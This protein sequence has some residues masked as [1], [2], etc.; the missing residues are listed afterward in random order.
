MVFFFYFLTASGGWTGS[1][2]EVKN[3]TNCHH[4]SFDLLQ[5]TYGVTRTGLAGSER[6]MAAALS[7][8]WVQERDPPDPR[9]RR[10]ER[11][12]PAGERIKASLSQ[13]GLCDAL[14]KKGEGIRTRQNS[15][16]HRNW[17]AAGALGAGVWEFQVKGIADERLRRD[18]LER[19][20]V[21]RF[22]WVSRKGSS[23]LG[24][25]AGLDR[26]VRGANGGSGNCGR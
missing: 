23:E 15:D 8:A 13:A 1:H 17:G 26:G 5:S 14:P 3:K 6:K 21:G 16:T 12:R 2:L 4:F 25:W 24:P 19:T 22:K 10:N 20:G 18:P 9:D 7:L 11:R